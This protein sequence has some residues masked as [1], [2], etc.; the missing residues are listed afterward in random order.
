MN[1]M[2]ERAARAVWEKRREACLRLYG[3]ELEPF[4]DGA[5]PRMNGVFDEV[6]AIFQAIREP[7]DDMIAGAYGEGPCAPGDWPTPEQAWPLMID[8]ILAE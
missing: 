7:T 8:A 3:D 6:I 2:I 4:G 1:E 5:V